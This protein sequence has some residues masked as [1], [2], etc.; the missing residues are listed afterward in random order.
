M[1]RKS[2]AEYEEQEDLKQNNEDQQEETVED[3]DYYANLYLQVGDNE[4]VFVGK[5]YCGPDEEDEEKE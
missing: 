3:D 2:R 4:P 1:R 5:V